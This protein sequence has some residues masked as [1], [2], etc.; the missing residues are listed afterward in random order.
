MTKKDL[1]YQL[2]DYLNKYPD[3][4]I[5]VD[6]ILE[7]INREN[8]CFERNNWNGHFTGSAW[9]V[10]DT[11]NWVLMTKHLQLNM[12]LQLG[13]HAEG[14]SN[15]FKVALKEAIEESGL[16]KFTAL[17]NQIFDLDIH[18]IPKFKNLPSHLHYDVRYIFEAK[19]KNEKIIISDESHD[20]S[21]VN[22]NDVLNK[23]SEESISR[24]LNKMKEY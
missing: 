17:S 6:N 22:K 18:Q 11:R 5:K 2:K 1:I 4:Q 23:N 9:I 21:W 12:W 13:G 10:D 8:E 19:I 20:V 3:E 24:M 15:L 16:T 14:N 7:F